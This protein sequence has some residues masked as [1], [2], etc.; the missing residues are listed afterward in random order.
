MSHT[1]YRCSIDCLKLLSSVLS[2]IKIHRELAFILTF[3]MPYT[4]NYKTSFYAKI[5]AL[6]CTKNEINFRGNIYWSIL[7]RLLIT[8]TKSQNCMFLWLF[9]WKILK[10][11]KLKVSNIVFFI[12]FLHISIIIYVIFSYKSRHLQRSSIDLV[13]KTFF[14][15]WHFD[16]QLHYVW[17]AKWNAKKRTCLNIG[18]KESNE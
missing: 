8:A 17:K 7:H 12:R 4:S 15:T 1:T 5:L 16:W 18:F 2:T 3:K 6:L 14:I 11:K 9:S 13:I 10:F